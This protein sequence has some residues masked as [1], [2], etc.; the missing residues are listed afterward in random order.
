MFR[1]NRKRFM[2]IVMQSLQFPFPSSRCPIRQGLSWN[3]TISLHSSPFINHSATTRNS[4]KFHSCETHKGSRLCGKPQPLRQTE[5]SSN[6]LHQIC[7]KHIQS[8]Q[9][10]SSQPLFQHHEPGIT[11][12]FMLTC[13]FGILIDTS[14]I[15]FYSFSYCLLTHIA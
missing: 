15:F 5:P 11:S 1:P 2:L 10:T 7:F 12:D 14:Q 6:K 9:H 8:W 4:H 3:I 13:N